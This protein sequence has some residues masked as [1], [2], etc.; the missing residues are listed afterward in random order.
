[1]NYT[2]QF[3]GLTYFHLSPR[4]VRI[5][6]PDGRNFRQI[7]PHNASISLRPDDVERTSGWITSEIDHDKFQ[8]EFFFPPAKITLA[9][10]N[11]KGDIVATTLADSL[12]TL[13]DVAP[14]AQVDPARAKVVGDLTIHRGEFAGFRLPG[15]P[16]DGNSA[17]I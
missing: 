9:G 16:D 3:I 1:M 8:T 13:R 6:L 10:A 14:E 12:Y 15:S 5:L 17:V 7:A 11:E 4:A 2:V